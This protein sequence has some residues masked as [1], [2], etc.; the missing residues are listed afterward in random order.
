MS[1]SSIIIK[2]SSCAKIERLSYYN[3]QYYLLPIIYDGCDILHDSYDSAETYNSP[4]IG[5]LVDGE[6]VPKY[7]LHT[8]CEPGA[9]LIDFEFIDTYNK[10]T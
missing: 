6:F 7:W 10:W 4:E 8:D 3:H 5:T 1:N 9:F 2:A